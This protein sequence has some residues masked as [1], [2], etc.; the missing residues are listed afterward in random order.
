M[1]SQQTGLPFETSDEEIRTALEDVSIPTL[2]VSCVHMSGDP[3]ILDGPVRP[4]GAMLNEIQ[5]Y[6]SEEDKAVA[7]E[8]AFGIITDYRDRGCP[9]PAPVAPALV[10]RMMDFG[11]GVEV[12]DEYVPMMLE[13]LG[14]EGLD[15]RPARSDRPVPDDFSVVVIGCGMSGLLAA[16]RLGQA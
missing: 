9:E 11:A 10:Q 16:I 8:L 4:Q 1:R 6:L 14:L 13:E 12:G 3:P 5:G 7:R 2:L 15:T